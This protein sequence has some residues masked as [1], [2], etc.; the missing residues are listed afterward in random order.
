MTRYC[1]SSLRF[2]SLGAKHSLLLA[3]MWV[4][5]G[6]WARRD[7]NPNTLV[8]HLNVDRF[9]LYSFHNIYY[10]YWKPLGELPGLLLMSMHLLHQGKDTQLASTSEQ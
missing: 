6:N 8:F 5:E 9:A 3:R 4:T 10:L 1:T 7:D 2:H